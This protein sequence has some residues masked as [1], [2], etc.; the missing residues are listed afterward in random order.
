MSQLIP[1]EC[2][3]CHAKWSLDYDQMQAYTDI[4]KSVD[5]AG[6]QAGSAGD[7]PPAAP[8]PGFGRLEEY[9]LRCP[10]PA[11]GEF[12]IIRLRIIDADATDDK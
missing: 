11:H 4:Y 1:L 6:S 7:P 12:V 8:E 2:P 5:D 3:H 10:N 9:R